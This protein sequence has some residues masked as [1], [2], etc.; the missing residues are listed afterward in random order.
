MTVLESHRAGLQVPL[1]ERERLPEQVR[2][3]AG[4]RSCRRPLDVVGEQRPEFRMRAAL[5]DHPCPTTRRQPPQVG[6]ALLGDQ[7]LGVVLGVVDVR[8]LGTIDEIAPFF[9]VDGLRNIDRYPL[10]AKSPDPPM[11]FMILVPITCVE[12]TFP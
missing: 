4:S 11:P 12:L 1:V 6:K 8:G 10:R 5:D 7:Y 3:L 2:R 9:A